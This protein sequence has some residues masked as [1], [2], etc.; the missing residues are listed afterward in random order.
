[1]SPFFHM[2]QA[3][4]NGHSYD[5][6]ARCRAVLTQLGLAAT[7]AALLVTPLT[8]GVA[9]DI[10]MV[11]LGRRKLCVKFARPKLKTAEDWRAPVHRN[12]AEYA[13]LSFAA[14]VAP[15][16]APRLF[17]SSPDQ[18]GFVMEYLHG[19]DISLWKDQLLAS[20]ACPVQA[21]AVGALLGRI[22]RASTE[23]GFDAAPFDN[24]TDFRALRIE[25]YLLFTA[26]R[27]PDLS[28][29][30]HDIA[31]R[32]SAHER[33]LIHGDVSP[34]NILFRGDAPLLLDAEC[35]TMGDPAFDLAFCLNHLILKGL[36]LPHAWSGFHA[37]AC[38]LWEAYAAHV[39]WEPAASVEKR[40]CALL[41][42]LMLARVDGK[43]P[44]EYLSAAAQ[45]KLRSIAA[46]LI[47]APPDTLAALLDEIAERME[48]E[49]P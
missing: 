43:S 47:A 1:M 31:A 16:N 18:H 29:L 12:R 8:G 28:N 6:E 7:D 40:L 35:A 39:E 3:V 24:G 19:D 25:P 46:P 15:Q 5:L 17:G 2:N 42:A 13:W 11:D 33:V 32:L 45:E 41:P 26:T 36:H 48:K 22:H 38:S 27:W 34:K 23:A 49:E 30:L 20:R 37:A 9:S 44:V 21:A 10:A 4:P 14:Q